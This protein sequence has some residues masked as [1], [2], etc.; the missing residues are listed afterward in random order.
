MTPKKK[1]Q[2]KKAVK[3]LKQKDI[4]A[5]LR[6]LGYKVTVLNAHP[7]NRG[8]IPDCLISVDGFPIFVEIKIDGDKLSKLQVNFAEEFK[9]G[10]LMIR[11]IPHD[12][13]FDVHQW[14]VSCRVIASKL[15]D[16]LNGAGK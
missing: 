9:K 6:K 5:R 7:S 11:Y 8:G 1:A 2:P 10:W 13:S 4:V 16:Q 15:Y 14:D 3:K 12:K